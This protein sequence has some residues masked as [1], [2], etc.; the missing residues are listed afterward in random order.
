[1]KKVRLV[2]PHT[3]AGQSQLVGDVIT[4]SLTVGEWLV[5]QGVGEWVETKSS[6]KKTANVNVSQSEVT[7]SEPTGENE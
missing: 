5:L 7:A 3:H 4:V 6:P 2:Q 1:M